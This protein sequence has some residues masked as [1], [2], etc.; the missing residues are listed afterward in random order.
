M[1]SGYAESEFTRPSRN[2]G[3]PRSPT[4]R[5]FRMRLGTLQLRH[6]IGGHRSYA[7]GHGR[8]RQFPGHEGLARLRQAIYSTTLTVKP[9]A[10]IP[11][12]S[13]PTVRSRVL[14]A[15]GLGVV[16]AIYVFYPLPALLV[17]APLRQPNE[18]APPPMVACL[19]PRSIPAPAPATGS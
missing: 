8:T 1:L 9:I 6:E 3:I 5:Q 12:L 16:C 15:V 2:A 10:S 17:V 14:F 11:A 19:P 18:G 13:P 7:G 4:T